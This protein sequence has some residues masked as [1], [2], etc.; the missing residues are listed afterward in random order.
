MKLDMVQ[1]M[2]SIEYSMGKDGILRYQ[3]RIVV[4][5][6]GGLR[7]RILQEIHNE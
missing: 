2:N 1:P 3:G 6:K 5:E 4:P 7:T